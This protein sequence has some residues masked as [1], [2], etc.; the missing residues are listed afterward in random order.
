MTRG[1]LNPGED[2][3][4]KPPTVTITPVDAV[5]TTDA[6]TLTAV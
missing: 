2:D 3:P 1:N 5:S 6:V 4:N